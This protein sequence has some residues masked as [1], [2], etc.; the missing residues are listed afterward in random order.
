MYLLLLMLFILL[1]ALAIRNIRRESGE[2]KTKLLLRYSLYGLAII[3]IGLTVTGR[4]H[5]IAGGIAALLPIIQ[6]ALP[7]VLRFLPFS[8]HNAHEQTK[9]AETTSQTMTIE[10]ALK[11]YGFNHTPNEDSII[12][13][14][15]ELIQ[16]NH[17]DRGGSDFLAA[18]INEA[19][20]VLLAAAKKTS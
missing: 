12:Q 7:W 16:K 6:R 20:D 17:P 1:G 18:Q 13:R 2:R 11:I 8:K 15:R 9:A 10:L 5:W 3:I 19:K 4:V 14:H